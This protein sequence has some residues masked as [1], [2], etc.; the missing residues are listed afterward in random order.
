MKIP[1]QII[2]GPHIYKVTFEKGLD[3][4]HNALGQ[5]RHTKGQIVL[6]PEQSTTQL[7][8]SFIHEML[9]CIDAQVKFASTTK[10]VA[11]DSIRRLSPM[12]LQVLKENNLLK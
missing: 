7:E 10:S 1:K 11:E 2:I 8:D 5:S 12:L 9:H 6:E 4:N 3:Y